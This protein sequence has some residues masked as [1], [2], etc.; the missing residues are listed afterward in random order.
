MAA[1]R[2]NRDPSHEEIDMMSPVPGGQYCVGEA[3]DARG[4]HGN[5]AAGALLASKALRS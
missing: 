2:K 5:I 4:G 1:R 3:G